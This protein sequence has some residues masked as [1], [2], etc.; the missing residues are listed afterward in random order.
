MAPAV[1][2]STATTGARMLSGLAVLSTIVAA[3]LLL[4][5]NPLADAFFAGWVLF[6]ILLALTGSLGAWTNR[7]PLVW[8]T[9]LLMTGLAIIGMWSIGFVI[10]PA[11]L[12]LL[13]AAVLSQLAGPREDVQAAIIADPPTVQEAVSKTVA[14]VG[15]VAIGGWLVYT[16]AITQHLFG[17]CATETLDCALAKTHWDAVGITSL[18]LLGIGLGA[19]L[20][21]RQ[22]YIGRVL[23]AANS[24][25]E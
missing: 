25:T 12:L 5:P 6:S 11:A 19:W 20:I 9:A 18:G 23:A 14:G 15:S 24:Q 22:I 7:T 4:S 17:A 13:G 21:W 1:Q 2:P 8:V 10:A 16:G 3:G